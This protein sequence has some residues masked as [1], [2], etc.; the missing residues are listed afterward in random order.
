M[1]PCLVSVVSAVA[2]FES[3]TDRLC[4]WFPW[5]MARP[6]PV[7]NDLPVFWFSRCN[8]CHGFQ[9][10]ATATPWFCRILNK[11]GFKN[12][13]RVFENFIRLGAIVWRTV[14]V[15]RQDPNL[16]LDFQFH[17]VDWEFVESLIA[18]FLLFFLLGFPLVKRV[19]VFRLGEDFLNV[20]GLQILASVPLDK[21]F[22]PPNLKG[23]SAVIFFLFS[24]DDS[25]AYPVAQV[26][27]SNKGS[28]I[29]SRN[30]V[31]K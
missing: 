13:P 6:Y 25:L 12:L 11:F 27:A 7:S 29:H 31:P 10:S 1:V 2:R 8:Q 30:Y 17:R 3:G 23:E 18:D 26:L 15:G 22:I 28:S 20:D 21:V 19:V 24:F 9:Y 16:D 4:G 5:A 14:T